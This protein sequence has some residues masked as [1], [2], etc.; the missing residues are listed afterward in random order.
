M[1]GKKSSALFKGFKD[2]LRYPVSF[3]GNA[4]FTSIK[5]DM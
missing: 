2:V 3:N 5:T 4:L 1:S